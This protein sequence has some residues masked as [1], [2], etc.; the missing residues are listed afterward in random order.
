[1]NNHR[2]PGFKQRHPFGTAAIILLFAPGIRAGDD[3]NRDHAEVVVG[4]QSAEAK[5]VLGGAKGVLGVPDVRRADGGWGFRIF[6]ESKRDSQGSGDS[7]RHSPH[8]HWVR[9][10]PTATMMDLSFLMPAG[11]PEG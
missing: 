3:V 2:N 1:M 7:R 9:G 8:R 4:E 10:N 5:E 11:M 6:R